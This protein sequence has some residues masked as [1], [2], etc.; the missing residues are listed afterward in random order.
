MKNQINYKQKYD[1]LIDKLK[2]L[3]QDTKPNN[4]VEEETDHRSYRDYW[5]GINC[6]NDRSIEFN[7]AYKCG[8][9]ESIYFLLREH[10]NGEAAIEP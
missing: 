7:N 3:Y 9:F 1:D 4:F 6:L 8:K 10:E 2:K 5:A